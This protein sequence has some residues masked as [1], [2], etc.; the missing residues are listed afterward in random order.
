MLCQE[1]K[2]RRKIKIVVDHYQ[3]KIYIKLREKR[4][5]DAADQFNNL[6]GMGLFMSKS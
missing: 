5:R 4:R 6:N 2:K 3:L 1:I